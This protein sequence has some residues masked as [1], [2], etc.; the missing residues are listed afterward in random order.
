MTDTSKSSETAA[1]FGSAM[2][3]FRL[4]LLT[5]GV[6]IL[7]GIIL[8][9]GKPA[10]VHYHAG[11]LVYIDGVRQDYS[12]MKYMN[13]TACSEHDTK[14]S[15]RE[16][17]IEKAHLHDGAGDVVHVHRTGSVWG[18][19]F[20]NINVSFPKGKSIYAYDA[21]NQGEK[22]ND[23]LRRPIQPSSRVVIIV[24]DDT[25]VKDNLE[26][27]TPARIQEVEAKSELCSS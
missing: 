21:D 6:L 26:F 2:R 24:G 10:H 5:I 19:L 23:I 3:K 4:P 16:E 9:G 20:K 25:A 11:F 13:F 15:V 7:L 27:V 14:K 12:D 1:K 22:I 18:D 17:Q 8:Y